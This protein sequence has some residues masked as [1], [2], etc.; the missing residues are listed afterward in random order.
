M[1][2][3]EVQRDEDREVKKEG[4]E[5]ENRC[6]QLGWEGKRSEAL[7]HSYFSSLHSIS[8]SFTLSDVCAEAKHRT[9]LSVSMLIFPPVTFKLAVCF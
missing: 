1:D 4:G 2:R 7:S 5:D 9:A 8:V 6:V 3:Q